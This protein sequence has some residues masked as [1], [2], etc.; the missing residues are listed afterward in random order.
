MDWGWANALSPV[1]V[2]FVGWWIKRTGE[3]RAERQLAASAAAKAAAEGAAA[4][5]REN[6]AKAAA[7]KDQLD[8]IEGKVDGTLSQAVKDLAAARAE[9]TALSVGWTDFK[10]KADRF[11]QTGTGAKALAEGIAAPVSAGATKG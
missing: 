6:L 11:L 2:V 5:A 9:I 7:A 4:L 8:V 3:K 10:A 1:A